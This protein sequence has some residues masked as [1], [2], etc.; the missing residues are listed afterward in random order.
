[1]KTFAAITD[2]KFLLVLPIP[3]TSYNYTIIT[4]IDVFLGGSEKLYK[5]KHKST[6]IHVSMPY[7]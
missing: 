5:P 3:D 6:T 4:I 1:M 2:C 7:E